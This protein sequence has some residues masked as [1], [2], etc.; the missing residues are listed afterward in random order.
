MLNITNHQGNANQNHR[1]ISLHIWQADSHQK[2]TLQCW[3]GY[4]ER[5][6]CALLAVMYI[7]A[8]NM[9]NGLKFPQKIEPPYDPAIPLQIHLF[10]ESENTN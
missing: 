9:E 5:T 4:D 1:D 3:Q 6:P 10:E 7:Y 8:A 2:D